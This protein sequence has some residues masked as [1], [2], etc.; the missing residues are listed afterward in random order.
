[1][2]AARIE[3]LPIIIFLAACLRFNFTGLEDLGKA[4]SR[5][6]KSAIHKAEVKLELNI[7]VVTQ[8]V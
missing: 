4:L 8:I 5:R 3:R 7:E 2:T 6:V 1:M